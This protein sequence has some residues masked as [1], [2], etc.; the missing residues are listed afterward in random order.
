MKITELTDL[1]AQY[2]RPVLLT[3]DGAQ[4]VL[5]TIGES[6]EFPLAAAA[7]QFCYPR[8]SSAAYLAYEKLQNGAEAIPAKALQPLYLRLPQA[9]REL[10]NKL[11]K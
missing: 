3:G 9:Q 5:E 4:K 8:A 11:K 2:N 6:C 10:N 7:E 1:L